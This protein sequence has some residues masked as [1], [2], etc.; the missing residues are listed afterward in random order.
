MVEQTVREFMK[1][2]LDAPA[3]GL[4][5]TNGHG[6]DFTEEELHTPATWGGVLQAH[7]HLMSVINRLERRI[8]ELEQRP[9][10][11]YEG[12]WNVGET[13]FVGQFVTE[14]G[15]LW[16]CR[17][18]NAGVKPGSNPDIWQLAVKHGRDAKGSR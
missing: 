1:A 8:L 15:S 9:T 18:A 12:T 2:L 13:F 11:S 4:V 7:S 14:A 16:A 6:D 17:K 5:R 10:M 3:S